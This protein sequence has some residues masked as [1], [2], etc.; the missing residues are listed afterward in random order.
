MKSPLTL[1][2]LD[3][4]GLSPTT[5]K[6]PIAQAKAPIMRSLFRDYP[7]VQLY[8]AEQHVGL[9]FGEMGNSEVGHLNIGAGKVIYQNLPRVNLA[10]S[11]GSFFKN[12][13]LMKAIATV[14]KNK[15]TLHYL[16]ICSNGGVHGHIEHL[17]AL[18]KL[19]KEEKVKN[20]RVHAI[21]DGR[22]TAPSIA[23]NF[24]E[25]LQEVMKAAKIGEIATVGGR[26]YAMD[27][28]T[29]WDRTRQMYDAMTRGSAKTHTDPIA[30]LAE[31]YKGD[32][33]D[34]MIPPTTIVDKKGGPIGLIKPGDAVI[35]FNF[36]PD[37]ARQLTQ[38][39]VL[40]DFSDF[41]RGEKIENLSF[42]TMMEYEK[43]LPVGVVF[44]PEIITM[45]LARVIAEK[46]W[47]QYHIAET[48]KYAHVTYFLNGGTEE[49]FA[50]EKR[51]LIPSPDVKTYDEKPEMSAA[52]VAK[53]L[54]GEIESGA[55]EFSV[56]NF[57][58]PDMVA[59]TGNYE[60]TL[61]AIE[62]VDVAVGR[63]VDA[64]LAQGG[65]V[66]ITADHGNAEGLVNAV[67]GEIDKEHST[68][69]VPLMLIDA[70]RKREKTDDELAAMRAETTPVGIL[71]DV[72]PTII[73]IMG[74]KKPKEMSG[75]SLLEYLT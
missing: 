48:E 31:S 44:P 1:I 26:Y 34:E 56:V 8:A 55:Y 19:A 14:K 73:D 9:K 50:G 38:A 5:E 75:N 32:V 28:N 23:T 53:T 20:V 39:F 24:L 58:N 47:K 61:E 18:I 74:L 13:V 60:A 30:L 46:G 62:A 64:T 52:A 22:D 70:E 57:A 12:D 10:I 36:R 72:A 2:I 7:W 66:L 6:N 25:T 71:A 15:S 42:T 45:P 67:T 59:H 63:V 54:V 40:E 33:T 37:R 17:H 21:T 68:M 41:D 29:K 49:P 65:C 11:D 27:R 3:G 16:G 43:G 69:P 35:F 4:Y 51:E